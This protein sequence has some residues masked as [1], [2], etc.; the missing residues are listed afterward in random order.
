MPV[1]QAYLLPY[2][3]DLPNDGGGVGLFQHGQL[4]DLLGDPGRDLNLRPR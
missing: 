2:V 4:I 1:Q 3:G